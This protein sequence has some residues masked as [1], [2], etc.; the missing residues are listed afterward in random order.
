M[1]TLARSRWVL[2]SSE[3]E[4]R[5][6]ANT[7]LHG[8][9]QHKERGM[10]GRAGERTAGGRTEGEEEERRRGEG[11]MLPWPLFGRKEKDAATADAFRTRNSGNE[12]EARVE[13]VALCLVWLGGGGGGGGG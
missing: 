1:K 9:K 2:C 6:R 13:L 5:S 3:C 7:L 11:R 4:A 12:S 10:R 8:T